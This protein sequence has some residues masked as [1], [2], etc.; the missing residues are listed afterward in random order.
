MELLNMQGQ[1]D[2]PADLAPVVAVAA[3]AFYGRYREPFVSNGV[4]IF[5][6]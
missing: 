2:V 4:W 1:C 3:G 6:V 5:H